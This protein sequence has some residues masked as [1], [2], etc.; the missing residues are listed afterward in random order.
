[1]CNGGVSLYTLRKVGYLEGAY[2]RLNTKVLE[3]N[4]HHAHFGTNYSCVTLYLKLATFEIPE[5][6][7]SKNQNN[8]L[9]LK[10]EPLLP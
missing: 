10:N 2:S 6:E 3:E 9:S 7:G 4:P 1:M 5:E 8:I